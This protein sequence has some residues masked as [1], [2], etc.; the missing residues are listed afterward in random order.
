MVFL[1]SFILFL[2]PILFELFSHPLILSISN[3]SQRRATKVS[4]LALHLFCGDWWWYGW[5]NGWMDGWW[6]GWMVMWLKVW[7]VIWL[8]V[9]HIKNYNNNNN[10]NSNIKTIK[11]PSV[12]ESLFLIRILNFVVQYSTM[13]GCLEWKK[14]RKNKKYSKRNTMLLLL[15]FLTISN[16]IKYVKRVFMKCFGL[17]TW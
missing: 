7:L 2:I 6:N 15:L 9:W 5:M 14:E 4:G 17:I 10:N 12:G 3:Y 8:V 11:T 13:S 16:F 1:Y